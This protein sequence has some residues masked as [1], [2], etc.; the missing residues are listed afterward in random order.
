MLLPFDRLG[1]L[2]WEIILEPV[3]FK[4]CSV[5]L[6]L[7]NFSIILE[8]VHKGFLSLDTKNQSSHSVRENWLLAFDK[9][10]L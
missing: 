8:I 3:N 4:A 1:K 5:N 6:C 7:Y 10:L 2:S 9:G